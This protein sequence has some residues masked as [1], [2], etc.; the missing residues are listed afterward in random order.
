[1]VD[2][3][4]VP[5]ECI[6]R[7]RREE[8]SS[9]TRSGAHVRSRPPGSARGSDGDEGS[10]SS[11]EDFAA[12]DGITMTQMDAVNVHEGNDLEA[13]LLPRGSSSDG[14]GD[15]PQP[16]SAA[17]K[18]PR[19]SKQGSRQGSGQDQRTGSH[20]QQHHRQQH[21]QQ[22]QQQQQQHG[23]DRFGAT[24]RR[25]R[26]E[27]SHV[28]ESLNLGGGGPCAHRAIVAGGAFYSFGTLA[29]AMAPLACGF[30]QRDPINEETA[31][32]GL[33]HR[34]FLLRAPMI[35][36]YT[37]EWMIVLM[38]VSPV[39]L[40]LTG[41][42]LY[43][44]S[45][46]LRGLLLSLFFMIFFFFFFFSAHGSFFSFFFFF[47]P[48]L[49]FA[50][51]TMKLALECPR[52]S[53]SMPMGTAAVDS[54]IRV[55]AVR[56][57]FF[58]TLVMTLIPA[59]GSTSPTL[60]GTIVALIACVLYGACLVGA[61]AGRNAG[62]VRRFFRSILAPPPVA[63]GTMVPLS[64][65]PPLP[66]APDARASAAAA[67]S[68][69]LIPVPHVAKTADG[70]ILACITCLWLPTLMV[71]AVAGS[72][73]Q[74]R[75]SS[76]AAEH[77]HDDDE[78]GPDGYTRTTG[79]D[80]VSQSAAASA[81]ASAAAL[82]LNSTATF[83]SN[84][85]SAIGGASPKMMA[86]AAA[87]AD[88]DGT[89]IAANEARAYAATW[90]ENGGFPNVLTER[91]HLIAGL[92]IVAAPIII[93]F[94]EL[95]RAARRARV[96]Q[97]AQQLEAHDGRFMFSLAPGIS[98][99]LIPSSTIPG[100]YTCTILADPS[101][102]ESYGPDA[103]AMLALVRSE[104]ERVGGSFRA[105]A[106][107]A[108]A[109]GGAA[110]GGSGGDTGAGIDASGSGASDDSGSDATNAS[111]AHSGPALPVLRRVTVVFNPLLERA[112][113]DRY[114]MLSDEQRLQLIR[115]WPRD[116]RQIDRAQVNITLMRS[117]Q[118][119]AAIPGLGGPAMALGSS[120]GGI[121]PLSSSASSSSSPGVPRASNPINLVWHGATPE[122][123]RNICRTGFLGSLAELNAG[124]Y[125]RG[126]YTS[127][128]PMYALYYAT[129]GLHQYEKMRAAD[130][131]H[132]LLLSWCLMGS[133]YPCVERMDRTTD[134]E[135]VWHAGYPGHDSHYA[136]VVSGGAPCEF[137]DVTGAPQFDFEE[138]VCFQENQL[139]PR[140]LVAFSAPAIPDL[141]WISQP[142]QQRRQQPG[143]GARPG[144]GQGQ[145]S[146]AHKPEIT[147]SQDRGM[148][149]AQARE[150][151]PAIEASV[152]STMA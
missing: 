2:E 80:D 89:V 132:T 126:I 120:R 4:G 127:T 66:G 61:S 116:E 68:A 96:A 95:L 101:A 20:H 128:Y 149:R 113:R 28:I 46:V 37:R 81:S 49:F 23:N 12:A 117:L 74:S 22:H 29:I 24:L 152:H 108:T 78:Q 151:L 19:R 60:V 65:T 86:A 54:L 94:L 52:C 21:Q 30:L 35:E 150:A 7:Q 114:L 145:G 1:M 62:Y 26:T 99:M 3:A 141:A 47:F 109:A 98:R 119:F 59:E 111:A 39:G 122:K 69:P 92:M 50:E 147:R 55:I 8:A 27:A 125:G 10:A 40:L 77:V 71:R 133:P 56:M 70:L 91:V 83:A 121:P 5:I 31:G 140:F 41:L 16:G 138:I 48:F 97:M 106:R 110:A 123:L 51:R 25:A 64:S 148:T 112:F 53:S 104:L 139:L 102:E 75:T 144:Q 130:G 44:M 63:V 115:P 34:N 88:T 33:V 129:A 72:L 58:A 85:A 42:S 18:Q 107:R 9:S 142:R 67:S 136:L 32:P 11:T 38:T 124:W 6:L 17:K 73:W 15:R 76:A 103:A 118:R 135:H 100:A 146:A 57:L 13:A 90:I 36:C 82:L 45:C 137:D 93:A 14:S 134:R 143:Q 84:F 79:T 131:T 87:S 43:F 105:A